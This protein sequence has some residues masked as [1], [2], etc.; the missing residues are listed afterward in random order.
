MQI[1][2]EEI[3][4]REQGYNYIFLWSEEYYQPTFYQHPVQERV[5]YS[6]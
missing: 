3:I 5:I 6:N 1:L 2:A 4:N